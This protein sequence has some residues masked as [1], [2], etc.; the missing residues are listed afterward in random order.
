MKKIIMT[1]LAIGSMAAMTAWQSK[2]ESVS[3]NAQANETPIERTVDNSVMALPRVVVYKTKADYSN[4]VPVNMND[5][6]T[7]IVSYPDPTDIKNNKR[8]TTL[9]D[10]FLLDNFG[11]GKNVA[12]LDYTYEQYAAL[13]QVPDMETLMQHISERNPLTAYYVSNKDYSRTDG[14]SVEALNTAIANGMAGFTP[15]EL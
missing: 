8:P 4:L 2:K 11:I 10:G 9:N 14:R 6:K 1:I 5:A 13:E 15:V 3:T 12:Y 7:E